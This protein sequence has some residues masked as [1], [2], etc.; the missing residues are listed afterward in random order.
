MMEILNRLFRSIVILIIVMIPSQF[1]LA[2]YEI[3]PSIFVHTNRVSSQC[4]FGIIN[5]PYSAI[6]AD[7]KISVLAPSSL[8]AQIAFEPI[9]GFD[10]GYPHDEFHSWTWPL[11]WD[12]T[13][14][15]PATYCTNFGNGTL[16]VETTIDLGHHSDANQNMTVKGKRKCFI[17]QELEEFKV[18]WQP[19]CW[20]VSETVFGISAVNESFGISYRA[21]SEPNWVCWFIA[22]IGGE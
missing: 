7:C 18:W 12:G 16:G 8:I 10:M 22:V 17:T 13:P 9:S 21:A 14:L 5:E 20:G 3:V 1:A 19:F 2:A 4:F 15:K 11:V 6:N